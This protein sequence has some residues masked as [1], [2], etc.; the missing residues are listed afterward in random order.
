MAQDLRRLEDRVSQGHAAAAG[1]RSK[2]TIEA[3]RNKLDLLVHVFIISTN[4]NHDQQLLGVS[5][6]RY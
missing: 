4:L 5:Q 1:R 3:T 2:L 6:R